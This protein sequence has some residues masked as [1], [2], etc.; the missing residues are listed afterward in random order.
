MNMCP[1]EPSNRALGL[2]SGGRGQELV[3]VVVCGISN[4]VV[5]IKIVKRRTILF[6]CL[7][8]EVLLLFLIG[9]YGRLPAE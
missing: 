7:F 1:D 5:Y 6:V 2:T 8:P 4:M 9:N 3:I